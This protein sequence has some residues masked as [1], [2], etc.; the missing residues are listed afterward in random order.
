VHAVARISLAFVAVVATG[1]LAGCGSAATLAPSPP[2]APPSVGASPAV[3]APTS[4]E[5]TQM[6]TTG[7]FS[8]SSSAFTD[9]SPIPAQY[10]CQGAD[11][12]PELAWS[13]VPS[14]AAALVLIVDDPD[15]NDFTHWLVLDMPGA[16]GSLPKGVPPGA[17]TPEQGRNDFG[18]IGWGGPCPP[19]G[20][21]H[22]RFT[23]YALG[24]KLGLDG[25]PGS[26]TVRAA[27]SKATV[28]G[29]AVLTGT[30]RRT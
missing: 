8:L 6:P 13:G 28:L 25:H 20:T 17:T 14:G 10:S 22:Y 12:S 26:S 11:I 3:T 19:S 18:R 15:A 29:Q 24:A 27:I 1:I 23:L 9:G 4:P 5:V 7:P 16:D 2:A 30:Y 21:H